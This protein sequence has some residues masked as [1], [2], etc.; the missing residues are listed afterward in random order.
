MSIGLYAPTINMVCIKASFVINPYEPLYNAIKCVESSNNPSA[1]NIKEQAY[2]E[3]QVRWIRITDY[4]QR[5]HSNYTL[6]DCLNSYVSHKVFM[7]YASMRHPSDYEH[8]ARS[9]NGSGPQT[10]I[11]WKKIV[12]KL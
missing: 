11:Y 8:I 6:K 10:E 12:S 7:F 2:G 1:V 4:N 5:T 3:V 9:W